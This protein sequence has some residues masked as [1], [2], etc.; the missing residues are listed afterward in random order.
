MSTRLDSR[1][2]W[3]IRRATASMLSG[4]CHSWNRTCTRSP[5]SL[6]RNRRQRRPAKRGLERARGLDAPPVAVLQ[7][8]RDDVR[9][10][11][12]P[13]WGRSVSPP[14]P[15]FQLLLEVHR[16]NHAPAVLGDPNPRRRARP[17]SRVYRRRPAHQCCD[18]SGAALGNQTGTRRPARPTRA[19]TEPPRPPHSPRLGTGHNLHAAVLLRYQAGDYRATPRLRGRGPPALAT[20]TVVPPTILRRRRA[21]NT[22]PVSPS[23]STACH[24]YS[25]P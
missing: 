17:R 1:I 15:V 25:G 12:S 21:P 6:D 9:G 20:T 10:A 4:G 23:L 2:S 11:W 3:A 16:R 24:R 13:A 5:L 18:R 22:R 7:H 19:R 14:S 8:H